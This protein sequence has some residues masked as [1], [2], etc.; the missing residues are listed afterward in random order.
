MGLAHGVR[1]A[2]HGGG[3]LEHDAHGAVACPGQLG[4]DRLG[5]CLAAVVADDDRRAAFGDQAHHR[6]ADAAAAAGHHR[7]LAGEAQQIFS[8]GE[9][10]PVPIM[11]TTSS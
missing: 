8:H 11:L 7:H 2:A 10:L 4:D 9:A 3:V 5:A 6:G 1:G